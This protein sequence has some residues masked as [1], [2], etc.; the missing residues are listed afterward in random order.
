MNLTEALSK[1][2]K[3][4]RLSNNNS[5]PAEAAA[6]AAKAQELITRFNLTI[7]RAALDG[8][9]DSAQPLEDV[10]DFEHDPLTKGTKLDR[11]VQQLALAIATGNNV[12]VWRKGP[13]LCLVGRP[14][15]VMTTRYLF[16]YLSR[17]IERLAAGACVGCGRTYWNNYRI[18]AVETIANRL[19]QQ[20][21][22][23]V[24]ALKREAANPHA[25]MVI[26]TN[27]ALAVKTKD[28]A[29]KL[30]YDLHKLRAGRSYSA[31]NYNHSAREAGRRDGHRVSLTRAGATL[32]GGSPRML[33]Q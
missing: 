18:G 24:D 30:A 10:A 5:N 19:R 7:D 31:S 22:E 3:L 32:S 4:L 25:L 23:T 26:D 15:D 20:H 11:W 1:A 21:R 6:A 9:Q 33:N 17:E 12:F 28:D 13:H 8:D 2:C 16:S 29:R 14:S 27:L